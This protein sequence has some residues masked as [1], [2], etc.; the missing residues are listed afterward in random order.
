MA[1]GQGDGFGLEKPLIGGWRSPR[2]RWPRLRNAKHQFRIIELQIFSVSWDGVEREECEADR[3]SPPGPSPDL[4]QER[5][6]EIQDELKIVPPDFSPA[7]I[8]R[9]PGV[10]F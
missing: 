9:G 6:I 8:D 10:G 7:L 1:I 4:R 3:N 2:L 5:R